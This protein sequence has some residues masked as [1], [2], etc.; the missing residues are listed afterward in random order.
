MEVVEWLLLFHY[1]QKEIVGDPS[2][3]V[4]KLVQLNLMNKGDFRKKG[5]LQYR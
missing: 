1:L 2:F 3:T 5:F 4:F